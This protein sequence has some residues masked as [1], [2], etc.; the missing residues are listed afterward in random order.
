MSIP[1]PAAPGTSD[2]EETD[3]VAR[4]RDAAATR[5]LL[6]TAGRQ[7]FAQ[8]GYSSTK[9]RDIAADAGVNVALINR[10]FTSK[11]GL[12]EACLATARDELGR[13]EGADSFETLMENMTRQVAGPPN[14]ERT[15]MMLLLLRS[16]GDD[17]ADRIRR[18]TL[19]YFAEQM[20]IA[21]G[22]NV[23]DAQGEDLSLRAQIA[24]STILG[25]ALLRSSST[26][27]EPLTSASVEGLE[28]PLT[29]VI[30]ALL[31]P[32]ARARA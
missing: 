23:E 16:S 12:F 20:S 3:T 25:I 28:G 11:E 31:A 17:G 27:L 14:G 7:R 21:A 10:Y 6:L 5:R 9:V 19:R 15:L 29:D 4:S 2:A 24:L 30:T 32:P 18:N 26:G 1:P 13:S 22:W 8:D